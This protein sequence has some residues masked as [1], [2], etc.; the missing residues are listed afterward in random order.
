[1]EF[2]TWKDDFSVNHPLMDEQHQLFLETLNSIAC[3]LGAIDSPEVFDRS[4][5][6]LQRYIEEHF[7]AEEAHLAAIDFPGLPAHKQQHDFF[8]SQVADLN[9]TYRQLSTRDLHGLLVFMR[10][11]LLSHILDMD[12][13]Y[14]DFPN[15]TA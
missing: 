11:W 7:H 5:A 12:R 6:M 10:D 13:Q 1:M 3:R 2:Y 9:G 8:R 14:A 4:V 15:T